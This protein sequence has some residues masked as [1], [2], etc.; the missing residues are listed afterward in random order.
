MCV[1]VCVCERE[2]ERDRQRQRERDRD[3]D[4]DRETERE[5]QRQ[6]QIR[7]K[8]NHIILIAKLAISK[9]KYG[10]CKNLTLIFEAELKMR[11]HEI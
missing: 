6:R 2:R 3:R 7:K 10:K 5:R 4:R 11:S 8:V 9:Y 1:C